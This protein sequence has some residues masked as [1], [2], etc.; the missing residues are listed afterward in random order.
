MLFN[1]MQNGMTPLHLAVWHSL[2]LHDEDCNTANTL[3]KYNANCNALDN[4]SI[5]YV[6]M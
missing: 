4:V 5:L 2:L 6:C 1:F 3:L